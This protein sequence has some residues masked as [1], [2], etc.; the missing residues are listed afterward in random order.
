MS[1]N[2]TENTRKS[3]IVANS[4]H[5]VATIRGELIEA[6]CEAARDFRV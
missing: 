2:Q 3:H 4:H 5:C 6:M 1:Q